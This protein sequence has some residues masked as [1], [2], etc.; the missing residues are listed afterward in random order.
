[1]SPIDRRRKAGPPPGQG[2]PPAS[3]DDCWN[4]HGIFSRSDERCE[5]LLEYGHCRNCPLYAEMGRRLLDRPIPDGYQEEL[6]RI[7]E[8]KPTAKPVKAATVFVFRAGDEWLALDSSLIHEV[9]PMGPIHTIPH[10][11]SRIFRGLVNVRGRLELC[12]S[13]GGVLRI[14]R[15]PRRLHQPERLILA[16]K[17]GQSVV[18]PVSEVLGHQV[19]PPERVKP[20]PVTVSGSKAVYTKGIVP[21]TERGIEVGLLDDQLL[22]RILTRNLG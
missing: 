12:V 5:R 13:I 15:A 18:F 11:S 14:E 17:K 16:V 2:G 9:V 21:I 19:V 8:Q 3:V 20:L 10:K 7:Y 1:M 22:F 6:T 4:R